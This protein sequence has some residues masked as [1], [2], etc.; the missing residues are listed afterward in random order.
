MTQLGV[1]FSTSDYLSPS[2]VELDKAVAAEL[3][4]GSNEYKPVYIDMEYDIL[5]IPFEHSVE[6]R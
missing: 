3:F 5:Q 2:Y 6:V 4:S 1:P